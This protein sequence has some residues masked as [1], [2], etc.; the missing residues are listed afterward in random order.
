MALAMAGSD[1]VLGREQND[2]EAP[3]A[4]GGGLDRLSAFQIGFDTGAAKCAAID[5]DEIKLRR[6][7]LPQSLQ[8]TEGNVEESAGEV[9]VNKENLTTLVEV[10]GKVFS[11]AHPPTLSFDTAN[12]ADA[13]RTKNASYCPA[14]NTINV[15][16]AALK[17]TSK[18]AGDEE[19]VLVQGDN[20]G[21]SIVTSRY[22]LAIQHDRGLSLDSPVAALRTACLTGVGQRG[23]V[24]PIKVSS[25]NQLVLTAGD[26]DEALAGLLTNGLVDSDVNGTTVPS[27]FT[28]IL[29]YREG[30]QTDANQCYQRFR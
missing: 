18:P 26:V 20:T 28:R 1:Q 7:N 25:G 9:E 14:T 2:F 27:G 24:D 16:L 5:A 4:H 29:A 3:Q 11:P 23:M 17:N 8:D 13:K 12:C 21:F 22:V 19:G 30:L 6:G 15:D 10:L